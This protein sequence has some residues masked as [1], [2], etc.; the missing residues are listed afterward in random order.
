M[1]FAPREVTLRDGRCVHVCAILP[2]DEEEILQAFDHMGP[3]ARYM[4]FM[5]PRRSANVE[6]LRAVLASFPEKGMAI[7]AT[8]PAADGIDIVGTASFMLTGEGGCEFAISITDDWAGA[9]LG[10]V[11]LEALVGA[12][13]DRGLAHMQGYVLATNPG[14]LRLAQRVG[15]EVR[16]DPEDRSVRIVTLILGRSP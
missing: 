14:M 15:F 8:V 4:R 16:A 6:R 13:R 7:A 12:A 1:P 2:T 9:G 5:S 3:E 10:R 11:L